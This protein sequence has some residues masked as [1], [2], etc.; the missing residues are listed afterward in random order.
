MGKHDVEAVFPVVFPQL[1]EVVDGD[2]FDLML[3]LRFRT[4]RKQRCRL[5]R[6][7]A[8]EKNTEAGKAVA[9]FC[10]M[11]I[12]C[13]AEK[14]GLNWTSNVWETVGQDQYG[15]SLGVLRSN[16]PFVMP[17]ND[18]LL[19]QQLVR[20]YTG[21]KR[22]PWSVDELGTVLGKAETLISNFERDKK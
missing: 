8:P 17:L 12:Q 9:K 19:N 14:T 4:Y 16:D 20:Y 13:Y 10:S 7:D 6:L 11:W 5:L 15:R 2:T 1:I 3:D 21:E 22:Y 18:Y